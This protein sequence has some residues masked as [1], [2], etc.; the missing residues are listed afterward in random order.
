MSFARWIE[1]S[2]TN[3]AQLASALSVNYSQKCTLHDMKM[4]LRC[5]VAAAAFV[6]CRPTSWLQCYVMCGYGSSVAA[7]RLH[8]CTLPQQWPSIH[9]H[10]SRVYMWNMKQYVSMW[11]NVF[12]MNDFRYRWP[13]N[14]VVLVAAAPNPAWRKTCWPSK[15]YTRVFTLSSSSSFSHFC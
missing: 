2:V 3:D 13:C 10:T 6:Q 15:N 14:F 4:D 9:T 1:I 8:V 5:S 12:T 7:C 11:V